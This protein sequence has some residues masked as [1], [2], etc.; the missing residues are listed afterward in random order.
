M[1]IGDTEVIH[2]STSSGTVS[3]NSLNPDRP[4]FSDYLKKTMMGA[5]R[6]TGLPGQRGLQAVNNH[7]WYFN[8]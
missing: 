5:R 7:P 4:N 6:L 1:Y 3:I 2:S 8:Q